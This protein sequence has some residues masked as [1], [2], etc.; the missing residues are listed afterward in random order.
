MLDMFG[1]SDTAGHM[2]SVIQRKEAPGYALTLQIHP[3]YGQSPNLTELLFSDI[4]AM[5][6]RL[7]EVIE[8][9]EW[10]YFPHV[11]GED[12]S[13]GFYSKLAYLQGRNRTFYLGSIF[14][15]ETVEMN[16]DF[17]KFAVERYLIGEQN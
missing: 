16:A 7:Y 5:G 2:V 14:N 17:A 12:L 11:S 1:T 10:Q 4:D 9:F 8:D 6:G 15:F 13:S 3:K